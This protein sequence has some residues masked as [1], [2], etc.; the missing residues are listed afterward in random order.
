MI[1]SSED[2]LNERRILFELIKKIDMKKTV[3]PSD[4][5]VGW[6]KKTNRVTI[7]LQSKSSKKDIKA[8][9]NCLDSDLTNLE[10][11]GFIKSIRDDYYVL[12]IKGM[13]KGIAILN[14]MDINDEL[15]LDQFVL[16]LFEDQIK[17]TV[18]GSQ[19]LNDTEKVWLLSI[20]ILNC[21]N[22][23]SSIDLLNNDVNKKNY[24]EL[25]NNT[26]EF[27]KSNKYISGLKK[28]DKKEIIRREIL[29]IDKKMPDITFAKKR[30]AFY[31]NIKD[32][33]DF[34]E[35]VTTLLKKIFTKVNG[36]HVTPEDI[37]K[38]RDFIVKCQPIF[39]SVERYTDENLK[40]D[41]RIDDVLQLF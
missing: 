24:V 40:P 35:T 1:E 15:L 28:I 7:L 39:Y 8:S 32:R 27:L 5:V 20:L 9:S 29:D 11:N 16:K 4:F 31:I 26:G 33:K 13:L 22:R 17:N 37:Q 36:T 12:T 41:P 23:D 14:S 18:K 3:N 2:N 21:F 19:A 6:L 30:E 10:Q 25:F 34:K 38:V